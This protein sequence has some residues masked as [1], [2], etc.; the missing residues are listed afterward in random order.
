MSEEGMTEGEM[1]DEGMLDVGMTDESIRK[2]KPR[3]IRVAVVISA[4]ALGLAGGGGMIAYFTHTNL[5]LTVQGLQKA[6]EAERGNLEVRNKKLATAYQGLQTAHAAEQASTRRL[7]QTAEELAKALQEAQARVKA[8]EVSQKAAEQQKS[9]LEAR[10]AKLETTVQ[11]LQTAYAAEQD[12]AKK[13]TQKAE[14]LSKA[15]EQAHARRTKAREEKPADLPGLNYALGVSYSKRGMKEEARNAFQ[16]AL[17]FDPNYAEA[18]FELARLYLVSFD[19]NRSATRH[20][21]Q[22]LALKPT[23]E[24]AERVKGW[25][26][27][28]EKE[29]N[30]DKQRQGWGKMGLVG[31]LRRIFE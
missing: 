7:G 6:S 19:D 11:G 26:M 16:T 31:G 27:K 23:A 2:P 12:T 24:D 25:L 20:F 21:R 13:L 8:M 3:K 15:L 1:P 22:Y 28:T 9:E 18:H 29:L 5:D 17:K 4:L 10:S 30:A 14:E